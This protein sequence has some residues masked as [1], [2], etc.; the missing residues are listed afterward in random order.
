LNLEFKFRKQ[1]KLSNSFRAVFAPRGRL[2]QDA[3]V[4]MQELHACAFMGKAN[5]GNDQVAIN[6]MAGKQEMFALITK[7]MNYNS[8]ELDKQIRLM[9]ADED[10]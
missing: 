1:K 4:V 9:E 10:E 7:L 5:T 6:K 3:Q 2:T 8:Y